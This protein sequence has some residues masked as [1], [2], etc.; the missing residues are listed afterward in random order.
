MKKKIKLCYI[1]GG[2]KMWAR[3]FMS[4]LA[5]SPFREGTIALYDIDR[6]AAER[7]KKIGEKMNEDP[8]TISPWIYEVH[9]TIETALRGSDVVVI[10]ILPGTFHEMHSD[11]HTP[12]KYGIY[13]SVG[14]TVG[15]G[16]VLRAMRTV[17]T[18]EY[19]AKKIQE[20]CPKAWVINLTNPM[21]LCVKTLYDVF[22]E[23]R[24]F[25]CCHEVFHTE[26]LLCDVAKECLNLP[27]KRN[28]VR[29]EVSGINHFTWFTE[30]KYKDIDLLS[31]LDDFF[32]H[33]KEGYYEHGPFDQY[34]WD[35]FAYQNKV[36]YDLYKRYGALPAAGDRHLVEFLEGSY[37]LSSMEAIKRW[38]FQ[39]TSVNFREK[40]QKERVEESIAMAEGKKK[41]VVEKS[42]EEVVELMEA[43][44][45]FRTKIS[46]VNLPNRGQMPDFPVRSIVETNCL[47]AHDGVTPL[48]AKPLSTGARALVLRNLNSLD[49]C[50]EG[51][52]KRNFEMIFTSFLAQSLC[53]GLSLQ[54]AKELFIEMVRNTKE[55]LKKDYDFSDEFLI[56][57]EK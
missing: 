22:P 27:L 3:I 6:E 35:P 54:N 33:H 16:G 41:V 29:F 13:Q 8:N 12:E 42:P 5:L 51:I 56:E 15:P 19:F 17:P 24:A 45:G 9:P 30:A 43:I 53:S 7:N 26:D 57:D 10:S 39:L 31:Y 23:I 21:N 36:K 40:Q 55:Y 4:D 34:L 38:G 18:Y 47:F 2:S 37:Y 52:K 28:E 50:Y 44:L 48:L 25:G 14:D 49:L 46:N 20:C 11:V 32:A 1:G